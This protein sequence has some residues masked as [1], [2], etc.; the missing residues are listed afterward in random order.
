VHAMCKKTETGWLPRRGRKW[1]SKMKTMKK[2]MTLLAVVGL[3]LA[4]APA[5]QADSVTVANGSFQLP[6]VTGTYGTIENV[7]DST[8]LPGWWV[9]QQYTPS[10]KI[11]LEGRDTGK[12]K[13]LA[14][15][16]DQY[17]LVINGTTIISQ[18]L[19]TVGAITGAGKEVLTLN[20]GAHRSASQLAANNR[21]FHAY[22]TLT[23]VK[24]EASALDTVV[25]PG[26]LIVERSYTIT[27]SA[28]IPTSFTDDYL[29]G[30]EHQVN[31]D[32]TGLDSGVEIGITF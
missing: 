17:P 8:S 24:H 16:G 25:G 30:I 28:A 19:G 29:P 23:G 32:T 2:M 15:N 3:V 26:G 5:A 31:L 18:D 4:L 27:L 13:A 20:F 14:Y 9:S 22:F 11:S 6:S 21:D 7:N 1:S 10:G 12:T